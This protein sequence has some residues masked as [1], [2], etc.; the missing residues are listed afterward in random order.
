MPRGGKRESAGRKSTW[1]SGCKFEDTKLIRVPTAIANKVLQAA[2]QIDTGIDLVTESKTKESDQ[3]GQGQL[4]LPGSEAVT[5]KLG[6]SAQIDVPAAIA[7]KLLKI[8][9]QLDEEM[10]LGSGKFNP[11]K[12][13]CPRCQSRRVVK[14]GRSGEKQRYE[15]SACGKKFFVALVP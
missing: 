8:A 9:R 6:E 14:D 3:A 13:P 10:S 12:P 15:C 7:E 2:H 5:W 4:S 1:V 11:D